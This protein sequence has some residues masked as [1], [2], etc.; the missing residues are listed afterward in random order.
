[1]DRKS[2]R[3]DRVGKTLANT[4]AFNP[5]TPVSTGQ[6]RPSGPIS[7]YQQAEQAYLIASQGGLPPAY[8]PGKSPKEIK[9]AG[10]GAFL[11]IDF[12]SWEMSL[13]VVLECGWAACWFEEGEDGEMK[14]RRDQGHWM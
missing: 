1:M 3:L 7:T 8:A 10:K 2:W 12:E 4:A 5:L 13:G 11:A 9:P 14:E 6:R